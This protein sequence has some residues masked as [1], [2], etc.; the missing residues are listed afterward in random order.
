MLEALEERAAQ[1]TREREAKTLIEARIEAM[2]SKLLTG[3][4]AG[5]LV[6]QTRA[7]DDLL[8][9]RNIELADQRRREREIRQQL[10]RQDENTA[11]YHGNFKTL[12]Q[13][14]EVKTRRFKKL[15]VK[16][17]QMRATI[18]DNLEANS[19]ERQ[20]L[21]SSISNMNKELKLK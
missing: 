14:V 17:Q 21:E 1:L 20:Q 15:V 6:D 13:E 4:G 5:S 18:Q 8:R 10:E 2:E 12:S 9:K 11:E 19:L 7:Q 16:Q 3:V